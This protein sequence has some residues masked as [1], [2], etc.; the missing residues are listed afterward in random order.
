MVG[1]VALDST[2]HA[3]VRS[4]TDHALPIA[5]RC[6]SAD[7]GNLDGGADGARAGLADSAGAGRS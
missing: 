6:V 4:T 1:N 5:D 7:L 3:A 2:M